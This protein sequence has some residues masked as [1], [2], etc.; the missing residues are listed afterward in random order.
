MAKENTVKEYDVKEYGE[1]EMQIEESRLDEIFPPILRERL[2][3]LRDGA[4]D[5]GGAYVLYW[6][7]HAVR[8]HANPALDTALVLANRLGLPALVYQGLG[9]PH[10]FNSD[11]HHTFILEGARDLAA[12][13]AERGI[14]YAFHLGRRPEDPTPLGKLVRRAAA[15]V[16]EDFPAPPFPRWTESVA[17]R[18]SGPVLAVDAC[19]VLPMRLVEKPYA[20]AHAFRSRVW[21]GMKERLERPWPEVEPEVEPYAADLGFAPVDL[22]AADIAEL[23]AACEIDHAVGPVPHTRGGT[24]AARVRWER[25]KAEGLEGY[26]RRRNDAGIVRPRGVSGMSPYLHHGHMSAWSLAREARTIGGQGAGK[27]LDELLVWRELAH[28]F[29]FHRRGDVETLAALPEWARKTLAEHAGDRREEVY[30]WE[31]LARGE[32]GDSLWDL[33]QRSLLV[34]GELHNNVRM[35]WGKALLRWTPSPEAALRFLI[36]LN[37]RYAL[38]GNDPSSY[39]GLLWCLGLFDRPFEPAKP[40]IGTVRPRSSGAHARRL[41]LAEYRRLV[42][43]PARADAPRVAVVGA[44]MA[45]V[46]AARTLRDHLL[47]VTVFDKARG[48][49]GRLSTR[50]H[51]VEDVALHFDHGAQYFTARDERFRRIVDAWIEEGVAQSWDG[52]IGVLKNGAVKSTR[53]TTER[54]VGVPGMSAMTRHLASSVEIVAGVRVG[55]IHREGEDEGSSWRLRAEDGCDLGRYDVVLVAVPPAQAVPLLAGSPALAARAGAVEMRPCWA[56]MAAFDSRLPLDLDGAFVDVSPLTW[57]ARNASKPDRPD[58]ETWILHASPEWTEAHLEDDAERVAYELLAAFLA[59]AGL[60][61]TV[62]SFL[63]AHRWRYA[64]AREP[65]EVGCLWDRE[66]RLGACGDWCQGSRVEGAFLS[67][68]AAAGRVLGLPEGEPLPGPGEQLGLFNPAS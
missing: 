8:A 64:L 59:A 46:F 20:R 49:G 57:V 22:A 65:L 32:T 1:S 12:Q 54:F 53:G 44:G 52:R 21:D 56:V 68:M 60:E 19:C 34:H 15:V 47:G 35:T 2:R 42:S 29:C 9:G 36:D 23:C 5:G 4:V 6:T 26:A 39:G 33:A 38:D 51:E 24:T 45:G 17:R 63:R 3:L 67:G 10:R 27:Y 37:H 50:R 43:R 41:D 48:P 7:H 30:S 18:S 62:A 25:F 58:A 16:V 31:R 13:L 66:R 14:A 61:T 55:E 28:N 11:R 40:V